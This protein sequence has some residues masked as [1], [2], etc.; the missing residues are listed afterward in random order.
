MVKNRRFRYLK[1]RGCVA[2]PAMR[3][4]VDSSEARLG[5]RRVGN[6]V[7]ELTARSEEVGAATRWL[8]FKAGAAAVLV[9]AAGAVAF[10]DGVQ[11]LCG[12]GDVA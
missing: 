7:G 6:C 8:E 4:R 12:G 10:G 9:A 2:L 5:S 11:S 3:A 1:R